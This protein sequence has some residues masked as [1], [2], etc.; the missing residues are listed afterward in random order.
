MG[1]T[2]NPQHTIP[3]LLTQTKSCCAATRAH[4]ANFSLL[5]M[6]EDTHSADLLVVSHTF[7]CT[8]LCFVFPASWIHQAKAV[9]PADALVS[10][11]RSLL[12]I[13]SGTRHWQL[14]FSTRRASGLLANPTLEF[15]NL[16]R[17]VMS[18]HLRLG[19]QRQNK[20]TSGLLCAAQKHYQGLEW[21]SRA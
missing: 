17:E 8:V 10:W 13:A 16:H 21:Q 18:P 7:R 6:R 3:M 1:F 5:T 19:V 15:R 4:P 2:A 9:S 20:N 11:P 12:P 14:R